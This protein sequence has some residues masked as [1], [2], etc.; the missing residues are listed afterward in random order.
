MSG[1]AVWTCCWPFL[2]GQVSP[3]FVLFWFWLLLFLTFKTNTG[4]WQ[5]RRWIPA[6]AVGIFPGRVIPVTRKLGIHWPPCLAPGAI[7]SAPGL[8]GLLSLYCDWLR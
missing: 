5:I 3:C 8:V 4:E 2:K 6:F 7:G 1:S